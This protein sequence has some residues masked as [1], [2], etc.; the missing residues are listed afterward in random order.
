MQSSSQI[1]TNKQTPSFLR[2]GCP[3]CRP[4]NSVK[5]LMRKISHLVDL[6][7]PNSPGVF[8]LCLWPLRVSG[9]LG[10]GLPCLI[11]PLMPVPHC[12]YHLFVSFC[13]YFSHCIQWRSKA[14]RGPGSTVT[15]GP[16]LSLPSTSPPSP[17]PPLPQP[18]PSPLPRSGP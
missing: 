9:S 16:S 12:K 14:V 15:W 1:I 10:G 3:S 7:P 11:C 2:A 4:T 18:S 8:Q 6:L 17:F 5:A 13:E